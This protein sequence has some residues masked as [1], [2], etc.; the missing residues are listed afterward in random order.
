[1]SKKITIPAIFASLII[2]YL[3]ALAG[4]QSSVE[5]N[6]WPLFAVCASISFLLHWLIFIPS[7][8]FQTEHYFLAQPFHMLPSIHLLQ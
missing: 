8:G 3:M 4:S 6:G 2:G 7:Y 5:F 1:M